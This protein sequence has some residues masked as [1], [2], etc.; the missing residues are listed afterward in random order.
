MASVR[1]RAAAGASPI[2]CCAIFCWNS[3]Q[4]GDAAQSDGGRRRAI[5]T[6][7]LDFRHF[8]P[9]VPDSL[10]IRA[11]PFISALNIRDLANYESPAN[12]V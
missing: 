4:V 6:G 9:E 12:G 8:S 3:I 7:L 2:R 11:Y 10:H 1:F 5:G